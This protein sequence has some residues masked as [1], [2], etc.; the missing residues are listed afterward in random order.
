[1]NRFSPFTLGFAVGV[2]AALFGLLVFTALGG[3]SVPAAPGVEQ[4]PVSGATAR[5]LK[6]T[7]D[8]SAKS[9]PLFEGGAVAEISLTESS[10]PQPRS[11]DIADANRGGTTIG[12][13][14]F[15]LCSRRAELR[16]I[17]AALGGNRGALAKQD[18]ERDCAAPSTTQTSGLHPSAWSK[19]DGAAFSSPW[20]PAP[21]QACAVDQRQS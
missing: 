11:E 13:T 9:D 8:H 2:V 6:D 19:V 5:M 10:E 1:M 21:R 15:D 14:Y 18:L 7:T 3:D 12:L 4:E 20:G 17:K 16:A